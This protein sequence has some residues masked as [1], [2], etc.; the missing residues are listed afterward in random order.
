LADEVKAGPITKGSSDVNDSEESQPLR[1]V[2]TRSGDFGL[3]MELG[4]QERSAIKQLKG[5]D[6]AL[7]EQIQVAV[8]ERLD[9]MGI[10]SSAEVLPV[11]FLY[12]VRDD[13]ATEPV[14]T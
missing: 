7:A 12:R 5:S 9:Q 1:L 3:F 6:G 10:G 13:F 11:V 8:E 4:R 14:E 2:V